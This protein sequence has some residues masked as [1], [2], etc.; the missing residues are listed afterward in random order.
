MSRVGVSVHPLALQMSAPPPPQQAPVD[1]DVQRFWVYKRGQLVL[2]ANSTPGPFLPTMKNDGDAQE[3]DWGSGQF[4][5]VEWEPRVRHLMKRACD[6]LDF[7]ERLEDRRYQ[8]DMTAPSHR[9]RPMRF[10]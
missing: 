7:V 4:M 2:M 1:D 6:L 10:L 9:V 8:V 3:C 5:S